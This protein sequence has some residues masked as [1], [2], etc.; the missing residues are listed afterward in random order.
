MRRILLLSALVMLVAFTGRRESMLGED[1][2]AW[3]EPNQ[4]YFAGTVVE[5]AK[6]S[7]L[8][9]F[10][11]GDNAVVARNR[12]KPFDIKLG[13]PVMAKWTDGKY[14]PGEVDNI[15]G[16]ALH[17]AFDDGDER[18]TSWAGIAVR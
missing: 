3:W 10:A 11:D 9:V 5:E 1:V 2:L 15:V 18:W 14:Y 16:R 4:V 6:D 17:I 8:I 13:S 7:L 12:V